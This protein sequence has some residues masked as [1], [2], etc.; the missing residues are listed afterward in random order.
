MDEEFKQEYIR[1][2]LNLSYK[3]FTPF[4]SKYQFKKLFGNNLRLSLTWRSNLLD[5]LV[6][7]TGLLDG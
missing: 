1:W 3:Q 2:K 4:E 6:K 5:L 7:R